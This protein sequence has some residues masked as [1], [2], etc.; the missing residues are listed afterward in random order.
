MSG[1][2]ERTGAVRRRL[3]YALCYIL[4]APTLLLYGLHVLGFETVGKGLC[5]MP[6]LAGMWL[7]RA[8]YKATLAHCGENLYVDFLAAIRTPKTCIGSDVYIGHSCW[9]GWAD[10]GDDVMLGGHI[11]VLSGAAQHSFERTDIPMRQ[12]EG[13]VSQVR[14]GRDVWVGNGAIIAADVAEGC[15]IGAGSVVIRTFPAFSVIAGVPARLVRSRL[16]PDASGQS[17]A[18]SHS[19]ASGN[20]MGLMGEGATPT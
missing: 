5:L 14:I 13:S 8:W 3:W 2:L 6:G 15:V 17:P 1:A 11:V 4:L 9:I 7:R 20:P 16:E 10:I 18:P 12:Q 19:E